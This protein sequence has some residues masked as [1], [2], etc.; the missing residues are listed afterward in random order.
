M[1]RRPGPS[2]VIVVALGLGLGAATA[3]FSVMRAVLLAP[4]PYPEPDRLV[5]VTTRDRATG[6]VVPR[7]SG[8]DGVDL[9]ASGAFIDLALVSGGEIGVQ[10]DGRGTF[11]G[12]AFAPSTLF[13]VLEVAP[14]AGRLYGADEGRSA[15]VSRGFAERHFGS[16]AAA[17]GRVLHV[18]Q[19]P[20]VIVGVLPATVDYPAGTE[21]WVRAPAVPGSQARTS[22][23]FRGI[24]RLAPGRTL[25][26]AR[27]AV[28]VTAA[29]LARTYPGTNLR[30][31]FLVQPLADEL[32]GS[33]AP[34]LRFLLSGAVLLLLLACLN[35]STLL[36]GRLAG[37]ATDVGLRLALGA[38]RLRVARELWAESA[39][40]AALGTGVGVVLAMWLVDVAPRLV[41][42]GLPDVPAGGDGW[43]VAFAAVAG[44]VAS[45]VA[46][47]APA[48]TVARLDVTAA[49]QQAGRGS[50]AG[51]GR[52]RFGL[53]TVQVALAL[54][55]AVAAGL[56]GRS[57][58]ALDRVDLGF[59]PEDVLVVYAH[60]PAGTDEEYARVARE[61]V[62]LGPELAAL[63]GVT[64]AA[65]AMGLPAGRYSMN[66]PYAIEGRPAAADR[67]A[68]EAGYRFASP[69]YFETLRIPVLAGRAVASG[70]D[71]AGARVAVISASLA[72]DVFGSPARAIGHRL[73]TRLSREWLT[74]V[75]VVGD[76]RQ[77][78]AVPPAALV[79]LPLVQ[80]PAFAN[81]VQIVVRARAHAARLAG[82]VIAA[83][84]RRHPD[85]ATS[86]L[87]LEEMIGTTVAPPRLRAWLAGVFAV[88]A[89]LLAALGVYGLAA[90]AVGTRTR[91][92]GVRLALGAHPRDLVCLVAWEG[93]GLVAGGLV[94][95]AVAAAW[96]GQ[97]VS[98]LLFGVTPFDP[99]S[100]GLAVLV[101]TMAVAVAMA[102][103]AMRA[104]RVDPIRSLRAE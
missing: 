99:W 73:R 21:V 47:A 25:T 8:P 43:A 23:A 36:L 37:R 81:E 88:V 52:I 66:G 62:A 77:A 58:L 59:D 48:W 19:A 22:L 55:L 15:V 74:I 60:A 75:G 5:S 2:L 30:R 28:D 6:R 20:I 40:L 41:P 67:P 95:G 14:A 71:Q 86:A 69:G 32:A 89:L 35:V 64:G 82:A 76:V 51:T 87:T 53:T 13:D 103:S 80:Y 57:L 34:A 78:P 90:L 31:D 101:I 4:L 27:A 56:T 72:R 1:L 42:G 85:V 7:L 97:F 61:L 63:P 44:M 46:A 26:E 49:L 10:V 9:E 98:P 93:A 104:A 100:I 33:A 92:L 70:D 11:A 96:L 54:V 24:G 12:V 16:M 39:L 68:P 83:V 84:A 79:Y 18:E 94:A 50:T 65:L 45:V 91:E 38:S 3:V 102:P 29:S 17:L